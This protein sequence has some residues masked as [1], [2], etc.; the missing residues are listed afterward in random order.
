MK[1][2]RPIFEMENVE[3]ADIMDVSIVKVG[4]I[5]KVI[6]KDENDN[7]IVVKATEVTVDISNL[8]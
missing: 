7:D 5:D 2:T 4:Y 8:F 6:G 3:T 1:Y